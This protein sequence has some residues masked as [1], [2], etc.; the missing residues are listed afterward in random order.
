MIGGEAF[1]VPC[2]G[3]LM[4]EGGDEEEGMVGGREGV[5]GLVGMC[6]EAACRSEESVEAWRRQRRTLRMLPTHLAHALFR[7]LLDRKLIS[8]S[9]LECALFCPD[10]VDLLLLLMAIFSLRL[11]PISASLF[12]FLWF[13]VYQYSLLKSIAFI[14]ILFLVVPL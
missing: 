3:I 14:F 1:Q 12:F 7:R 6:I 5:D 2:D 9:L 11:Q 4:E 10:L 13:S 8:P